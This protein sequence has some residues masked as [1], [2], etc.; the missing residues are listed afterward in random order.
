MSEGQLAQQAGVEAVI[1]GLP[2]V[3]MDIT[4]MNFTN[5]PSPR[6]A[7]ANEFLHVLSVPDT[8]WSTQS[9]DSQRQPDSAGCD[10][11][12]ALRNPQSRRDLPVGLPG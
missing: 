3:M 8:S 7:P 5:R 9:T 6:G 4:M 12:R 10:E 2:L 11:S 1:Y